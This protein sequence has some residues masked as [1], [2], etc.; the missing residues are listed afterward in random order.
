[1]FVRG[2]RNT[3][4]NLIESSWLKNKHIAALE[5]I[6][7]CVKAGGVGTV[8]SSSRFQTVFSSNGVPRTS[9]PLKVIIFI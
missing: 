5:F 6:C 3:V 8:S 7:T 2:W 9:S 1:M 4:G